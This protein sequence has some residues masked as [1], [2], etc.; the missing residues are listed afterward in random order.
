MTE[1]TPRRPWRMSED[2]LARL[3]RREAPTPIARRIL[4]GVVAVLA[5]L[6]VLSTIAASAKASPPQPDPAPALDYSTPRVSRMAF[7]WPTVALD[8]FRAD[9]VTFEPEES[10]CSQVGAARWS[11]VVW[12]VRY[13]PD[14]DSAGDPVMRR[15]TARL[16]RCV[17]SRR[18]REHAYYRRARGGHAARIVVQREGA[19]AGGAVCLARIVNGWR[20]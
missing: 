13:G 8:R 19:M 1:T 12:Y 2:E 9:G 20:S 14:E 18:V 17:A 11:C 16:T 4:L 10:T 5:V 3:E 7:E 6:A 15:R